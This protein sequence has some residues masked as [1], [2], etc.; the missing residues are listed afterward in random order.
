MALCVVA[1][2]LIVTA[3]SVSPYEPDNSSAVYTEQVARTTYL[4]GEVVA[5]QSDTSK[6]RLL[7]GPRS[8]Q[9]RD[10]PVAALTFAE[11]RE[12]VG[13]IVLVT[14]GVSSETITDKWRLP[15]LI[16][17]LLVF[18]LAIVLI[19]RKRGVTGAIGLA[20]S[21]AIIALY[22]VPQVLSGAN[23]LTTIGSAA[24]VI[25]FVSLYVAHGF[26]RRTTI[27]LM[28]T[29]IVLVMV[30]GIAFISGWF[31]QLTGRYDETTSLLAISTANIDMR[32]VLVGGMIIATLGVL[33]DIITAQVA[34]VDQLRQAN[35]SYGTRELYKRASA[36]GSEHIAS[37]INTLALAYVGVSLPIILSIVASQYS[38][39]IPALLNSEFIAQE[40][41]RTVVSS[42]G[43]L[44]AVPV[45]TF[46]AA[47]LLC[48]WD[49]IAGILKTRLL[50]K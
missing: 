37:L 6:V 45:S 26:N 48:H 17:L 15:Q 27:A 10:I 8:G 46:M 11:D 3:F 39:N 7:D 21:V 14:E 25:A 32:G 43:L 2:L 34:V 1:G 47:V 22:V 29:L 44:V 40:V 28:A 31:V 4:R 38:Y 24:I 23:A 50:R 19:G 12:R 41:T 5:V 42:L 9:L 36:V 49:R 35:H 13:Q 33:D 30:I 20:I 16:L 18:L